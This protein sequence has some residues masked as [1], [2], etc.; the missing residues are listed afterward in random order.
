M[1]LIDENSREND[2]VVFT[3]G[4][5]KS[6]EKSGW[7]YTVRGNDLVVAEGSGE[8]EITTSRMQMEIKAITEALKWLHLE[9]QR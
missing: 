4:S 9:N 3:D 7:G 6:G 1:R 5:I 2:S 8:F